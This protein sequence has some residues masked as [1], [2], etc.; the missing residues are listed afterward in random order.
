MSRTGTS[1]PVRVR[2]IDSGE[3]SSRQDALAAEEPLEVR[4]SRPSG[5]DAVAVTTTMR[6]P[7][8]DFELAAG[9]LHAEGLL[10][11][12]RALRSVRYC[13]D[14]ASDGEQLYN[15]VTV[16]LVTAPQRSALAEL[17][18]RVSATSAC[19]LCGRASV[20]ELMSADLPPAEAGSP[21][22]S[23]ATIC[24][25]PAAL[26][27]E[28][29]VFDRTGG[30]HAAGLFEAS[31]E[32]L[33]VREDIGRHNA[34]D[35][36][37]GWALLAGRL[38]L[39]D[40]VLMVSGRAGYEIVQKAAMAGIPVVASVSAPSSLAV[41]AAERVGMTLVGFVRGDRLNIYCGEERVIPPS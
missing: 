31:G 36:L 24:S 8:H 18:R 39:G 27:K 4:L 29:S 26:R 5:E 41:A 37:V 3:V 21:L 38:P 16:D 33:C 7:G 1:V 13:V 30:L 35:K 23:A 12:K 9:F 32:L 2:V 15:I 11:D 17:E 10:P 34:V 28:Q 40:Q 6:T 22:V 19:G 25:L 20:D 14:A